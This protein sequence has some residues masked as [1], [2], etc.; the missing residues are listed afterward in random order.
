MTEHKKES[1]FHGKVKELNECANKR[2]N[3]K[4]GKII[5]CGNLDEEKYKLL[6]SSSNTHCS[7]GPHSHPKKWMI[8][9]SR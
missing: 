1:I 5:I 3:S 7:Y 4:A 8:S 9:V 6:S 2:E